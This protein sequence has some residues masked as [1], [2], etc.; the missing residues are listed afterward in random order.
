MNWFLLSEASG[1]E[2]TAAAM[3]CELENLL[4]LLRMRCCCCC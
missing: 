2:E 1:E 3:G 4:V